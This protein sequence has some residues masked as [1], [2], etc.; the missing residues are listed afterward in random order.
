MPAQPRRDG[1]IGRRGRGGAARVR[2][3]VEDG[4]HRRG[5]ARDATRARD[6]LAE[7]ERAAR[8]RYDAVRDEVAALGPP[9]RLGGEAALVDEWRSLVEWA[10]T[11]ADKRRGRSD[12]TCR[13]GRVDRRSPGGAGRPRSS[14]GA[15]S[16]MSASPRAPSPAARRGRRS[17]RRQ[18][19]TRSL[20]RAGR[21]RRRSCEVSSSAVET[22]RDVARGLATHL[23]ARHFEK[24]VLDEAL[25]ALAEGATEVLEH[26]VRS[27]STRC[28][29]TPRAASSW[30]IIATRE[31]CA[32]LA[33]C[34]AARRSSPRSRLPSR[35]PTA[36]RSSRRTAQH[37]SS[38]SSST[39]G[40]ARSTPTRSTRWR[41][42]SR[43]SAR[44][45]GWSASS[46]TSR[47][48][49]S[50][51]RFASRCSRSGNASTI[52]RVDR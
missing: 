48:W 25:T 12:P 31:R 37:G 8:H 32:R 11:E 43:S 17:V 27:G 29:S 44:P 39:R 33:R 36:S 3:D 15:G 5:S 14:S 7:D 30:S 49:P 24:W 35:S 40:S 10:G 9:A 41:R 52:E 21:R 51:C 23:D 50:V 28:A 45:A 1:H 4:R 6:E 2:Q 18:P 20:G 38:R 34:R 22:R 16:K 13:A 19:T 47:I 42:P 46:A 26:A